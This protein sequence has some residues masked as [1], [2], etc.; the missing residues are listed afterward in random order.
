MAMIPMKYEGGVETYTVANGIYARVY[1]EVVVLSFQ[2]GANEFTLP[3]NLRPSADI[4]TLVRGTT[5]N[6]TRHICLV[7]ITTSGSCST[8]YFIPNSTTAS[9]FT[10]VLNGEVTYIR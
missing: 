2:G 5:A 8:S 6:N 4:A 1:G 10:G 3:A 7:T 9:G